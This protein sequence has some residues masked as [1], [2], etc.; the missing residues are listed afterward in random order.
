MTVLDPSEHGDWVIWHPREDGL[1][2]GTLP[3]RSRHVQLATFH[4]DALQ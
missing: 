2:H 1:T 4:V 3:P